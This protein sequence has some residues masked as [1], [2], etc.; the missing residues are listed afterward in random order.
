M[1]RSPTQMVFPP[2][3]FAIM[4]TT[5]VLCRPFHLKLVLCGPP[6]ES[7]VPALRCRVLSYSGDGRPQVVTATSITGTRNGVN[8]ARP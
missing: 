5:H 2:L 7:D 8:R 6:R 1:Q 4:P 3:P